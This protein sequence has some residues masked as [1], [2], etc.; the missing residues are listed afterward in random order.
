MGSYGTRRYGFGSFGVGEGGDDEE[1][2]PS[3]QVVA[4]GGRRGRA[5]ILDPLPRPRFT[6]RP[7]RVKTAQD[8][9]LDVRATHRSVIALPNINQPGV[10]LPPP[11]PDVE[12]IAGH[13]RHRGSMT[14]SDAAEKHIQRVLLD[15]VRVLQLLGLHD[16]AAVTLTLLLQRQLEPPPRTEV[17]YDEI[18]D[19]GPGETLA[20]RN[21]GRDG[22]A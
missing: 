17:W 11:S 14:I 2:P 5:T 18:G 9:T 1:T 13:W 16:E 15:D 7:P 12:V 8:I 4:D 6:F 19:D 10:V 3:G 21:S 22:G 20:T